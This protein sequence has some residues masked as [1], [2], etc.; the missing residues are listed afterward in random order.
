MKQKED[1]SRDE[2][3]ARRFFE[4]GLSLEVTRV[5]EGKQ[6]TP[7]YKID[8]DPP[9]YVVEVK[10]RHDDHEF[11]KDIRRE[12]HALRVR[13]S[14]FHRWTV[15]TARRACKQ[16]EK[17]DPKQDRWWVLW[18][19]ISTK[20]GQRILFDQIVN[21][22]YGVKEIAYWDDKQGT[23]VSRDCLL[24][25]CGAFEKYPELNA[26]IVV[27]GDQIRLCV[28][29]LKGDDKGFVGSRLYGSF[30]KFHPPVSIDDLVQNRGF[31]KVEPDQIQRRDEE[32]VRKFLEAKYGFA[33]VQV[34][35]MK[36]IT[37]T[38]EI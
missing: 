27:L 6:L 19:A 36:V 34:L 7:D 31:L 4:E 9:G 10:S 11:E 29:D 20:S 32:S 22:L 1:E 2:A 15:D 35:N 30:A 8:G 33:G 5:V 38:L 37:D 13:E 26:A 16:M 17:L 12:G 21:S 14:S 18:I 3:D 24:A 23:A 25:V 28:S